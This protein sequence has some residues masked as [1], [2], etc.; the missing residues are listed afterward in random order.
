VKEYVDCQENLRVLYLSDNKLGGKT[1]TDVLK[2]I[3][4]PRKNNTLKKLYLNG[5]N[6]EADESCQAMC[7]LVANQ[8]TLQYLAIK[9]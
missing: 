5:C 3:D 6:F 2:V 1:L 9:D 7:S 8:H 4:A